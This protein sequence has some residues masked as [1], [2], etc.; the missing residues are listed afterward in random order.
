MDQKRIKAE[1]GTQPTDS[2]SVQQN[3]ELLSLLYP[4]TVQERNY[5]SLNEG[6]RPAAEAVM[7]LVIHNYPNL[8]MI[9]GLNS[10]NPAGNNPDMKEAQIAYIMNCLRWKNENGASAIGVS[11]QATV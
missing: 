8:S 9:A 11:Q 7:G 6:W 5:L 3:S 2:L 10:F 1:M 4:M